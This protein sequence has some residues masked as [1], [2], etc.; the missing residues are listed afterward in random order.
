MGSRIALAVLLLAAAAAVLALVGVA[1]FYSSLLP[2]GT[3][4]PEGSCSFLLV[5]ALLFVGFLGGALWLFG[6]R[7]E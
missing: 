4:R 2:H 7:D 3:G 6:Q 5:S 1:W